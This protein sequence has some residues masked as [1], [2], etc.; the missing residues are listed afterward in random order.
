MTYTFTGN[1]P[2]W[3]IQYDAQDG[4]AGN[5]AGVAPGTPYRIMGKPG[6]P[7]WACSAPGV[8]G[9]IIYVDFETFRLYRKPYRAEVSKDFQFGTDQVAVR[10][11]NR[12]DAHSLFRSPITGTTGAATFSAIVTR[13]GSGT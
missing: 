9:D 7:C 8:A 1:A 4:L 12:L 11:V 2:A 10:L 5:G 6:Y 13:T 3:G